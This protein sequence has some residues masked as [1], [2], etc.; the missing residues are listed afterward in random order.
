M[1]ASPDIELHQDTGKTID[2]EG[3]WRL[4]RVPNYREWE[5]WVIHG[6]DVWAE[7]LRAASHKLGSYT[8][9]DANP[10]VCP[11]CG[12]GVPE[13]LQTLW[14]LHNYDSIQNHTRQY[15]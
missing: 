9:C 7:H 13:R 5:S 6:C 15:R 12:E 1:N 4:V 14:I 8:N 11:L 2:R 10:P 3:R